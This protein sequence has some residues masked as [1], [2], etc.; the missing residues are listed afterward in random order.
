M[1]E[2]KINYLEPP[3]SRG[4]RSPSVAIVEA[5]TPELAEAILRDTYTRKGRGDGSYLR[6]VRTEEYGKPA[7][8]GRVLLI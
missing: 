1:K 7:S 4:P 5:E 3:F 6:I 2:Y 8:C